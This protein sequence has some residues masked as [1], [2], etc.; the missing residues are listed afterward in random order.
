MGQPDLSAPAEALNVFQG[1]PRA[2]ALEELVVREPE[3]VASQLRAWITED[4]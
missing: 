2:L 3:R 4:K 1:D